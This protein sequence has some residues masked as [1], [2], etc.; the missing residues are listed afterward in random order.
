MT[1][2]LRIA[3]VGAGY[4]GRSHAFGYRNASMAEDLKDVHVILDTIVDTNEALAK[5]VAGFYG[6]ENVS[7]DLDAVLARD[8]IDAVSLAL[9]NRLYKH[10]LPK[11]AA[12]GKNIF[13]EKPLGLDADEAIAL[14]KAA[15]DAGVI[16]EVGFSFRRIP[17]LAKLHDL[18][19]AGAFGQIR[20]F[21]AFYYADYAA[22]PR[23]PL[24]WRYIMKDSGGGAIA[25]IGAHALDTVRY[26]VGDIEEVVSAALTTSIST[27]PLPAGGIGHSQKASETESG[28]VDNDDNA[29][30]TL[31]AKSGAIGTVQ[32]SRIATGKPNDLG[33]EIYGEKGWA[34]FSSAAMDEL[35]VYEAGVSE[36]G[37]DGARTVIAGPAFPYFGDTAAMPG[38]GVGTGYGEAF[39]AEIQEF[40]RALAYGTPVT[41]PFSEAIPTMKVIQ[42]AQASARKGAPVPVE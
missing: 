29:V 16:N 32:L 30:V 13:C 4:A 17:A 19:Q 35:Q 7:T 20:Q 14:A 26:V 9:P 22:D 24:T 6:F 12:A 41:T 37:M 11:V 28:P 15:E 36:A 27:R 5:D 10:V 38:R 2:T 42:A 21:N 1:T 33:I 23:Q 8:D 39:I 34:R 3:L 18:V 40:V 25:D 31:R